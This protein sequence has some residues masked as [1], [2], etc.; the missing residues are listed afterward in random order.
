[1]SFLPLTNFAD[2]CVRHRH[3]PP[4]GAGR[5]RLQVASYGSI[6][7]NCNCQRN[8]CGSTC[9]DICLECPA[10]AVANVYLIPLAPSSHATATSVANGDNNFGDG[11]ALNGVPLTRADPLTFL[12]GAS[13]ELC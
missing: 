2:R 13:R 3:R 9:N 7:V 4:A 5:G 10:Q 1:M 12:A 8:S 11:I 6:A